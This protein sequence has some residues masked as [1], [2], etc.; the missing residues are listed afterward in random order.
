MSAFGTVCAGRTLR[1]RVH[2]RLLS[3]IPSKVTCCQW[4]AWDYYVEVTAR[5]GYTNSLSVV[6]VDLLEQSSLS[7]GERL[8]TANV[9]IPNP[10]P[11]QIIPFVMQ[12]LC[13]LFDSCAFSLCF[14]QGF[15]CQ[16]Y[17]QSYPAAGVVLLDPF[18]PRPGEMRVVV[19][20]NPVCDTCTQQRWLVGLANFVLGVFAHR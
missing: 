5:S 12:P 1:C 17:L 18:P 7:Y 16:Q 10:P 9:D 19:A 13:F 11:I 4:R 6:V 3:S 14:R 2:A 20:G 8:R 15:V